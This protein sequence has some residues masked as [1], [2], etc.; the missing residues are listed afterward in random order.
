MSSYLLAA[1]VW[2]ALLY[3]LAVGKEAVLQL[4]L[5]G[6]WLVLVGVLLVSLARLVVG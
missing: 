6:S 3:I 4:S 5:L 2:A 1:L